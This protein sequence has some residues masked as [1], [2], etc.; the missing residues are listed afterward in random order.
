MEAVYH[1]VGLCFAGPLYSTGKSGLVWRV[2]EV[3]AFQAQSGAERIV[4]ASLAGDLTIEKVAAIELNRGLIGEDF[5]YAAAVGVLQARG[6]PEYGIAALA[7]HPSVIV[8]TT[9]LEGFK[10]ITHTCADGAGCGEIHRSAV[11]RSD[12]T[13]RDEP[14]I[15][16]KIAVR[17]QHQFVVVG[18]AVE[19]EFAM[20]CG[21]QRLRNFFSKI[22]SLRSEK[23]EAYG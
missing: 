23:L 17:C 6:H 20:R 10:I 11:D 2:G 1:G 22:F 18:F 12:R 7:E 8:A 14:G 21:W 16:G 15:R 19:S 3:F 13:R 5:H 4:H 9:E